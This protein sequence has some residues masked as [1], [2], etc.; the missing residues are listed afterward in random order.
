VPLIKR[1]PLGP[2]LA[3]AGQGI[4]IGIIDDGVDQAHPF[5]SPPVPDAQRLPEGK[6]RLHDAKVI[7]A[8][9]FPPPAR[10][11]STPPPVRPVNSEHA[12]HVAGI[13]AGDYN[14]TQRNGRPV[15]GV[16]PRAYIGNYKVL[17]VPTP[18]VGL[19]GNSPEIVKGIDAAVATG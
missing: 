17:T 11:G 12:T 8:R 14:T 3:T 2:K 5:F 9:A 1:P 19:N 15:S 16:A 10:R 6:H 4:K 18:G 13:A 7:V